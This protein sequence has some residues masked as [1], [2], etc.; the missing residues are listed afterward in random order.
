MAVHRQNYHKTGQYIE[1]AHRLGLPR[2]AL[3]PVI[4]AGRAREA[5]LAPTPSQFAQ[6]VKRAAEKARELAVHVTF[7]CAPFTPTI[8]K[9]KYTTTWSCRQTNAADLDPAGKILLCDTLDIEL[10]DASTG[11]QKA[12]Q[13]Y[14]NHPLVK[15]VRN[16][17][18]LPQPCKE[19]PIADTCKAGCFARAYLQTGKLTAPDPLCPRTQQI[20]AVVD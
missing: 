12:L 5:R 6:A 8:V 14:Q 15:A 7:W 9:N 3:I 20:G 16:P 4:P 18:P 1:L 17:H 10:A 2:V 11:L 19:C 13:Q